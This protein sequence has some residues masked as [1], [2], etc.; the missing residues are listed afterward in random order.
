[1]D[2]GST[3]IRDLRKA[4]QAGDIFQLGQNEYITIISVRPGEVMYGLGAFKLDMHRDAPQELMRTAIAMPYKTF[5]KW[6][7]TI[8]AGRRVDTPPPA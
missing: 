3:A 5:R 1:M 6:L 8:A 2:Q 7:A 4:P